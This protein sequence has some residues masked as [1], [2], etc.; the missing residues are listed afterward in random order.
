MDVPP[1]G[2]PSKAKVLSK[3]VLETAALVRPKR[4]REKRM[5]RNSKSSVIPSNGVSRR[6]VLAGAG[7]A[8]MML[9]N[10]YGAFAADSENVLKVGFISPRTGPLGSFGQTDGYVLDL[11]SKAVANGIKIGDKTYKIE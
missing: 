8:S 2:H 9:V 4:G 5:T 10:P 11:A 3:R 7:A 1:L 6:D